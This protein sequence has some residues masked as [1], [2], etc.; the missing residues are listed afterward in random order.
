MS[1]REPITCHVLDTVTGKPAASIKVTLSTV[2]RI[3][4][5]ITTSTPTYQAHTDIDGRVTKWS[6]L[7]EFGAPTLSSLMQR[8]RRDFPLVVMMWS[9]KFDVDT[10]Y[11]GECLFPEV[12]VKFKTPNADGVDRWH[13]PL[14]LSPHSYTTYRG[15]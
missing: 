8:T 3:D 5:E 9:L 4:N 7:P 15:S 13:V 10:Y 11:G 1:G 12:E 14:L 2:A 6:L